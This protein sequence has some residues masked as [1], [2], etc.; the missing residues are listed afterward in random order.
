MSACTVA[1]FSVANEKACV[2]QYGVP[3]ILVVD[4]DWSTNVTKVG[5][6]HDVHE[7]GSP[8]AGKTELFSLT[9]WK[10]KTADAISINMTC[11]FMSCEY[12]PGYLAVNTNHLGHRMSFPAT[13]VGGDRK[14]LAATAE[15]G[16]GRVGLDG[17]NMPVTGDPK[18]SDH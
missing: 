9:Q 15:G 8:S 17:C 13:V 14:L 16:S 1:V 6:L 18:L 3:T 4:V 11:F 5:L 2:E 7:L 10:A 12:T